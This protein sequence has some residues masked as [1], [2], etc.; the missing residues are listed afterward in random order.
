MNLAQIVQSHALSF[1]HLTSPDLLLGL[2]TDPAQAQRL[3]PDRGQPAT[4]PRRHP[5][6]PVRPGDHRIARRQADPSRLGRS[7]AASANRSPPRRR[8]RILAGIPE[9]LATAGRALDWFKGALDRF[10]EEIRTFGNFPSLFMGL[11]GDDGTLEHYDGK[12][13][14]VD[15]GGH[16]VADGLDPARLRRR[17]SA[18]RSSPGPT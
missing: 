4:G 11:V 1:F 5:P 2:D 17:T 15:A 3:R 18:R 12:L 7:P 6:A 14:F 9:A 16:I 8:D 13:R 10:R